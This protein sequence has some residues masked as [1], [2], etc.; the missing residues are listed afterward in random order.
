M[1]TINASCSTN[2]GT[3][4]YL[5][6]SNFAF[7]SNPNGDNQATLNQLAS[8]IQT[9]YNASSGVNDFNGIVALQEIGHLAKRTLGMAND[10]GRISNIRLQ[11]L[12]INAG[13]VTL[14]TNI[15]N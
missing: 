8:A 5:T 3:H 6:M 2:G 10:A 11:G 12:V 14:H 1:S 13:G 15:T 9:S 4:G 7:A